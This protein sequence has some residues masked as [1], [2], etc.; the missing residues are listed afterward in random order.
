MNKL[1][2]KMRIKFLVSSGLQNRKI[3]VPKGIL[4]EHPASGPHTP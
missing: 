1:L 4:W 3:P 2:D